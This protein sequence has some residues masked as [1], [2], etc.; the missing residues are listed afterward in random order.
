MRVTSILETAVPLEGNVS[1]SLVNFSEHTVTLVAV[2][3]DVVRNGKPVTGFAFNSIGR[4]AQSGLLRER[5][6]P[7]LMAAQPQS[8]LNVS[9]SVF[10]AEKVLA[11]MMR[12]EKPGGHGDRAAAV[13][14]VELA[15]WDLNAKLRDEPAF[16]TI[17]GH[18]GRKVQPGGLPAYAAGGY[19][20]ADD[21]L[22][23]LKSELRSYQELGF[24]Q[25]KIKIG[26]A[27]LKTDIARIEAA[28]SV[29]GG[30]N[31]L[32]VDA[33]GRFD[34]ATGQ[35]YARA[36]ASYDLRWY[37]EIGDPLDY[38]LNRMVIQ[39]YDG[40]VATGENLF[41]VPDVKNLLRYGGMRVAHDIFQM[42][43]GLSYGLTEYLRMVEV[44]ESAGFGRDSIYPHGG[45]L[46]NL[47]I[48]TGLGLG[49]CEA[50]PGV[51]QP[52]GGYPP[53]CALGDGRVSPTDAPGFG[54]EQKAELAPFL[55]KLVSNL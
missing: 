38:E 51:F 42:D 9:G 50:Y 3:S 13:A 32:A 19:Y 46:I 54:L 23:R 5:F 35:A 39:E 40:R 15:F 37:E 20:F 52:F 55:K 11:A 1:N 53:G 43:A 33:N 45:H 27:S 14:A 47:H 16:Q 30:G 48:S 24:T 26:G 18:V 34:L 10:D 4:Y 7:R 44:V 29:A 6:I 17:A 2:V 41:S 8:L 21:S 36:I 22:D 25:F 31:N 12:N 28:L 49:G